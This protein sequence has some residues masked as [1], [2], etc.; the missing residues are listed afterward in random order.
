MERDMMI[1]KK[2]IIIATECEKKKRTPF[3]NTSTQS[4]IENG[5]ERERVR[6]RNT[7]AQ[8]IT[9]MWSTKNRKTGSFGGR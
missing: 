7:P 6:E 3:I 2:K 4:Y 8:I 5:S 1:V 9:T